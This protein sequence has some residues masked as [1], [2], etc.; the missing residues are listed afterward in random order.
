MPSNKWINHEKY[1]QRCKEKLAW[2]QN[3]LDNAVLE[4]MDARGEWLDYEYGPYFIPD[5]VRLK[6]KEAAA[7][8]RRFIIIRNYWRRELRITQNSI[9][10]YGKYRKIDTDKNYK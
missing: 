2:A 3:K 1:L 4:K 7:K 6:Y 9:R 5:D 8:V 10:K